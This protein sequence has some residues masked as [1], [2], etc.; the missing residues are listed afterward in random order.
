MKSQRRVFI[1]GVDHRIQYLN[2]AC[3]PEWTAEVRRFQS[4]L[5]VEARERQV[6][7]LVEEFNQSLVQANGAS[8]STVQEIATQI[9]VDHSFCDPDAQE[10]EAHSID[11][12]GA[13][14]GYWLDRLRSSGSLSILF[15]CGDDHVDSF[16]RLLNQSGFEAMVL[17]KGWGQGWQFKN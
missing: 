7:G 9:K 14:E 11:T 4:Y 1:V 5:L 3:G 17:S 15:V 8:E 10:R 2:A 13:R 16:C 6:D 12:Q